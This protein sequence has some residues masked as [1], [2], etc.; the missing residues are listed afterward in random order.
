[1]HC[2]GTVPGCAFRAP[3]A[4]IVRLDEGSAR[5]FSLRARNVRP[6]WF[7]FAYR[8]AGGA[9]WERA[10][11][12]GHGSKLGS[13][14]GA[15]AMSTGVRPVVRTGRLRPPTS[16]VKPD[17]P[18]E[19]GLTPGGESLPGNALAV[20]VGLNTAPRPAF[21]AMPT[22]RMLLLHGALVPPEFE[23]RAK[24]K[25]SNA[26]KVIWKRRLRP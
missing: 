21:N 19:S 17:G 3:F 18:L 11:P 9:T 4:Q 2:L 24:I 13:G 25:N 10:R 15:V 8:R 16:G 23:P 7:R 22:A 5:G 14:L 12:N 6:G 26:R 1:M 20:G